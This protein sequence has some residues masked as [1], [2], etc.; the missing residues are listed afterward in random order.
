MQY[1]GGGDAWP[2]ES[3]ELFVQYRYHLGNEAGNDER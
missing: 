3:P 2:S 1:L